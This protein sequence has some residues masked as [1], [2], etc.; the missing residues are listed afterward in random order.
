MDRKQLRVEL[1][2]KRLNLNALQQQAAA[3]RLTENLTTLDEFRQAQKISA[4]VAM[5]GE[6]DPSTSLEFALTANK[7]CYLPIMT[8]KRLRFAPWSKTSVMEQKNLGILEPET[9]AADLINPEDLDLVL[10]PLV[11][12]DSRGNRLGMGG[13][14]Y[15]RSF[16]FRQNKAILKPRLIGIAHQCQQLESID[17]QDW[18]VTLD[19][20]VTDECIYT[21]KAN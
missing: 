12:F 14:F 5:K 1:R 13:G 16:S 18:D 6:I 9:A 19:M 3:A 7:T 4:Y 8:G 20:V 2:N 17:A 15:D 21:F 10:V 11:G